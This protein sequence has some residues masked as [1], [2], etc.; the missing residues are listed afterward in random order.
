MDQSEISKRI[1]NGEYTL[2]KFDGKSECWKLFRK[3]LKINH[4]Y[5]C[6]QFAS[7]LFQ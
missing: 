5:I 1:K 7:F 6:R 4:M 3:T 2:S